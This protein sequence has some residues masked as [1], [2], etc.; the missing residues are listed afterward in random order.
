MNFVAIERYSVETVSR[1]SAP[2][3]YI[4]QTWIV[5]FPGLPVVIVHYNCEKL[6]NKRYMFISRIGPINEYP[7]KDYRN[8]GL[9][10]SI[11]YM[12]EITPSTKWAIQKLPS[13]NTHKIP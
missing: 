6:E 9:L 8:T 13:H 1:R 10:N 3:A 5:S 4:A 2:L 7:N 12:N 11:F